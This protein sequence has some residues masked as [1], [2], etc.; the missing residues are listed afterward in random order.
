[1][2]RPLRGHLHAIKTY[3]IKITL[4]ISVVKGQIQIC[5]VYWHANCNTKVS[6]LTPIFAFFYYTIS[7]L[8]G[9]K[10]NLCSLT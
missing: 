2:F 1:M 5:I 10:Y 8:Q 4:A 9:Y 6:N 3:N 7:P